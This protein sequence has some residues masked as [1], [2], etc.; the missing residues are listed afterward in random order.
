M[1]NNIQE[2]IQKLLAVPYNT[3]YALEENLMEKLKKEFFEKCYVDV[4]YNI[5]ENIY[6]SEEPV[7]TAFEIDLSAEELLRRSEEMQ[8]DAAMFFRWLNI[9]NRN[10]FYICGDAGTGKSVFLHWLKYCDEQKDE[11]LKR[12]W[13]IIDVSESTEKIKILDKQVK[14]QNFRS[15][16][17]KVISA[18]IRLLEQILYS[19]NDSDGRINHSATVGKFKNISSAFHHYFDWTYPDEQIRTIFRNLPLPNNGDLKNDNDVSEDC[20]HYLVDVFQRIID[21]K[22]EKDALE[23]FIQ[24]YLF[25]LFCLYNNCK[26]VLAIDNVER[27]IGD[28]ELY[29]SEITQFASDLR[30]IHN[31]IYD[32]N[33]CLRNEY[34]II[35]FMR[36][37]SV[38]MVIPQQITDFHA[39]ALDMSEWFDVEAI[40]DNKL[41]W[42][43]D[44][45]ESIPIAEEILS[46]L[47]DNINYEGKLRGLYTK[48]SMIFNNNKRVI[49]HFLINVLGKTSNRKYVAKFNDY[50]NRSIEGMTNSLSQFAARSIVYRLLLNE[51]RQDDFFTAIMTEPSSNAPVHSNYNNS[52]RV[53]SYGSVGLGYARKILTLAYEY[54]LQNPNDPYAPLSGI[55]QRM[56]NLNPNNIGWLYNE[57][58]ESRRKEISGILFAMNYYDGRKGD[59]L[60][61]ID[62]QYDNIS[63]SIRVPNADVMQEI[64][65]S[66]INRLKI[67]IT[68]AGIAYLYFIAYSFEYFA[69]KSINSKI[70][71]EIIGYYDTPPLLSTIPSQKQIMGSC[72]KDLDCVKI[73]EVVLLEALKCIIKMNS[74]E[75]LGINSIPFVENIGG[76]P[77]KHSNR[78]VNYHTGYIDNFLNCIAEMYETEDRTNSKFHAHYYYFVKTIHELRDLYSSDARGS[79]ENYKDA[80]Q[81]IL[82]KNQSE[83]NKLQ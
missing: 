53:G 6:T 60:Q 34:K 38:R 54:K 83:K 24:I 52:A 51:M 73:I 28:D 55:L 46:I 63:K 57:E 12:K 62:I 7:K 10:V 1:N 26:F 17:Y 50:R 59:W 15:I 44:Q 75:D 82:A 36:N 68:T 65:E 58:N 29:N 13:A 67:K 66:G 22:S 56:F 21:N 78:I 61:F 81:K 40:L 3:V 48:I 14:V 41:K 45:G 2:I 31:N 27:I 23:L 20:G 37:T 72:L 16:Y 4:S 18:I 64:F 49:V 19:E 47:K 80:I 30:T 9:P 11:S 76:H 71:R 35:V 69:C 25:T 39:S 32:N 74:N 77:I 79:I 42:Y 70:H 8:Q 33:E 43:S 5:Q